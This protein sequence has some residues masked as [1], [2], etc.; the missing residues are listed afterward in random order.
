M[1]GCS[2]VRTAAGSQLPAR[3]ISHDG[4]LC[5]PFIGDRVQAVDGRQGGLLF[6]MAASCEPNVSNA[7]PAT[8][9]AYAARCAAGLIEDKSIELRA[10]P[11]S[12]LSEFYESAA[13][14][15]D[16]HAKADAQIILDA[17]DE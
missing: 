14:A 4:V 11:I 15:Y 7:L 13:A 5:C 1:L 12:M 6:R 9:I 10:E 17:G 8:Q 16:S 2:L 3:C